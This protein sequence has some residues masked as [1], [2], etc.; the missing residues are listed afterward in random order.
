MI[1]RSHVKKLTNEKK[2]NSQDQC[3]EIKKTRSYPFVV[4]KSSISNAGK[5]V[6]TTIP[7]KK[8][9]LVGEYKGKVYTKKQYNE[10]IDNV[11]DSM[12]VLEVYK[13]NSHKCYYVDAVDVKTANH[14]RFINAPNKVK[15]ENCKFEY[16]FSN[17]PNI[18]NKKK[19]RTPVVYTTKD[20]PANTELFVD[21]GEDYWSAF[22]HLKKK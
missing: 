22:A 2:F 4:K 9:Y 15:D 21:Y 10:N 6:F 11:Q 12:Y 13:T 5:G 20:I 18:T 14:T 17:T 1:L 19:I 8:N 3:K 16:I 7:L